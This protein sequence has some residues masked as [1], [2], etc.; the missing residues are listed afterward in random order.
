MKRNS[1]VFDSFAIVSFL[2]GEPGSDTVKDYLLKV[3]SKHVAGYI[4]AVN[5]CEV[6]YIA[7]RERGYEQ[8]QMLATSLRD[9]GLN[10]VPADED[11]AKRAGWLK[12]QYPMALADAFAAATSEEIGACLLTGDSEFRKLEGKT[13]IEWL[14]S[15]RRK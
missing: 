2:K 4:S 10:V 13:E 15:R 1:I 3:Q 8:A 7:A 11:M 14:S 6:Y 9:W 5:L 12:A